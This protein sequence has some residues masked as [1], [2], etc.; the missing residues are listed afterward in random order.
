[1]QFTSSSCPTDIAEL[2]NKDFTSIV[3]AHDN[4]TNF[5]SP[6]LNTTNKNILSEL[7]LSIDDVLA[8]LLNL[9]TNK[10]MGPDDISPRL[11]RKT[12]HQIVPLLS[13]LFNK[14]LSSGS[15]LNEWKLANNRTSVQER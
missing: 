14:S 12:A 10:G 11:L 9:D 13:Q 15:L 1:M 5:T 8:A 2:F 7:V 4:E 3:A 6:P